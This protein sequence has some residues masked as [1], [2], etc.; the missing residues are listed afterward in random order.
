MDALNVGLPKVRTL[1]REGEGPLFEFGPTTGGN[2][3]IGG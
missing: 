1:N 3:V 2:N